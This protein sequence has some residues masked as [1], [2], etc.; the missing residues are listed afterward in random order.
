MAGVSKT[1]PLASKPTTTTVNVDIE[2]QDPIT[3]SS[4]VTPKSGSSSHLKYISLVVLVVQNASLILVMRYTR[5]V[6][7][8][9]YFSTTAVVV[10]EFLKLSTCLVII[11]IQR[12]G[13]FPAFCGYL[14]S[15]I[16]GKPVDTLKLAIPAL[17]YTIQNNLLY[18]AISNLSAATFQVTYQ[19][20]IL[21]TALFSV[22]LLQRSLSRVQWMSLVIL[23]VGVAIVQVQPTDPSKQ[24]TETG[25]EHTEQNPLLGLVAVIVSCLSS[26][27]AGV[28]FEK[29]LKGSSASI[30]LMNIQFG[31]YGTI[32]GLIGMWMKEG[33]AVQDKG[34]FFGYTSLVW[35][36]VC[37]QAFGGLLVAVV[38]KYADNILKG[39]ATSAAII[40]STICAVYFFGFQ[41]NMQF[42][43]GASLV[44]FAV[45]LY[46]RPKPST[47]P[48]IGETKTS[49]STDKS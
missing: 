17:A 33:A 29:I 1:D 24:H 4:I 44:I 47:G 19:L 9:M 16:I 22:L 41:I 5:T 36:V 25:T 18:V 40:I 48:L 11:F 31:M 38:V 12:H 49:I 42:T 30:W 3:V 46:S 10:T 39:F 34:F 14:H 27:F 37:W 7:G 45:Y 21:T 26:G 2:K 23:F 32:I 6:K 28:Y 13:N 15:N 35:F 43:F 8:D 20:K